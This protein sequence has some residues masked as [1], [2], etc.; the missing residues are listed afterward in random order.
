MTVPEDAVVSD[1]D[2]NGNELKR[3]KLNSDYDDT[4]TYIPRE[5]VRN[6]AIGMMGKLRKGLVNKCDRWIKMR[7]ITSD[8]EEWLVR[9]Q[10]NGIYR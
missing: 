8:I 10:I 9:T 1:K 6:D 3:R 7:N 2:D 4:Q 5:N